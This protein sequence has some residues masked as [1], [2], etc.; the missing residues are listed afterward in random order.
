V[1]GIVGGNEGGTI[2]NCYSA[3][4]ITG[5][6][7]VGGI[8]G[9]SDGTITSCY[10]TGTITGRE[11]V[12]GIVGQNLGYTVV[13]QI[14][15]GKASSRIARRKGISRGMITNCYARATVTGEKT[16]GGLVG[17]NRSLCSSARFQ[18]KMLSMDENVGGIPGEK[19][20]GTITKCYSTG[21]I[22]GHENV[23][24]IVGENDGTITDC[25]TTGAITGDRDVGGIAGWNGEGTITN[26]FTTGAITGDGIVGGI[27]GGNGGTITSCYAT[28]AITGRGGVG[29]LAGEN[30]DSIIN[31]YAAGT[32][33][34]DEMV[35]GIAG[36]TWK[37]KPGSRLRTFCDVKRG[38]EYEDEN[39][40]DTVTNCYWDMERCGSKVDSKKNGRTTAQMT[41]PFDFF[42][43]KN[44]DF[45]K[46][47]VY[48]KKK[49]IN[50]G[51]PY[52]RRVPPTQTT[53]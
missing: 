6:L 2:T 4:T 20:L 16:V 37:D 28:G 18:I 51:Y 11:H 3:G 15:A 24:G 40:D 25:Y 29:G 22:T 39:D 30:D 44:W 52:L 38:E 13:G 34:G 42:T 5:E 32:I 46:T 23:G 49:V 14:K 9:G 12:G 48:D 47:W 36:K 50:D 26:C 17:T 10:G 33:T 7:G 21:A 41:Y 53:E 27:V 31:C 8:A 35:G 45:S 1:G 19:N 43:Y